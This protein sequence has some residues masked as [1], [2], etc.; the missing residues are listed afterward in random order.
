MDE[1]EEL[2]W[3]GDGDDEVLPTEVGRESV[4]GMGRIEQ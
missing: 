3:R 1:D 4:Q 2:P